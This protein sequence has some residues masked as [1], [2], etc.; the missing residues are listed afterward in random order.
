MH[1]CGLDATC[2]WLSKLTLGMVSIFV[3]HIDKHDNSVS[4]LQRLEIFLTTHFSLSATFIL[5][6]FFKWN[7]QL[8]SHRLDQMRSFCISFLL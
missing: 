6:P 3:Y 1:L 2:E 5:V 8:A 7:K 4:D